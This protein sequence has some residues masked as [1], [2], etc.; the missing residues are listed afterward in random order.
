M[1][2]AFWATALLMACPSGIDIHVK[3][4]SIDLTAKSAPVSAVIDCLAD[5]LGIQVVYLDGAPPAKNVN[6]DLRGQTSLQAIEN[7]FIETGLNYVLG[8]DVSGKVKK[9][10][11]SKRGAAP[12][13]GRPAPAPAYPGGDPMGGE[14]PAGEIP[15]PEPMDTPV[16]VPNGAPMQGGYPTPSAYPPAGYPP[17]PYSGAPGSTPFPST[18]PPPG[19][20]TYPPPGMA[21]PP[22]YPG[23]PYGQPGGLS[24]SAPQPAP[25]PPY[26]PQPQPLTRSY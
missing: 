19:G 18:Y 26:Y 14:Y 4:E 10:I 1:Y 15:T 23:A 12:V 22:A 21:N 2:L 3:G 6:L 5:E 25:P 24:S 9:V 17:P 16:P 8:K 20:S 11:V 7:V 13:P